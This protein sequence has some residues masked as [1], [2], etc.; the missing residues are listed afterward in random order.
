MCIKKHGN[1]NLTKIN[2]LNCFPSIIKL[3]TEKFNSFDMYVMGIY[4]LIG[5]GFFWY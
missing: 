1:K 2:D 4:S 3:S 5:S